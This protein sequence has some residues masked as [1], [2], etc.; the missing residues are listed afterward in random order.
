LQLK[1]DKSVNNIEEQKNIFL[2]ILDS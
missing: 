1:S 2:I